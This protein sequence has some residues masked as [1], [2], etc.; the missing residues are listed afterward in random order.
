[1]SRA[2]LNFF[3]H[4]IWSSWQQIMT[5]LFYPL[6]EKWALHIF[7]GIISSKLYTHKCRLYRQQPYRSCINIERAL[8]IGSFS[9]FHNICRRF[10]YIYIRGSRDTLRLKARN[11]GIVLRRNNMCSSISQLL[12]LQQKRRRRRKAS[13]AFVWHTQILEGSKPFVFLCLLPM[14]KFN[15]YYFF[16][17]QERIW[18][19]SSRRASSGSFR[20]SKKTELKVNGREKLIPAQ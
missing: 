18:W 4:I 3:L 20:K 6:A 13:L 5:T 10:I 9:F 15:F 11:Q 14:L 7:R 8:D 2:F 1:M 19:E 17:V 12:V 16:S